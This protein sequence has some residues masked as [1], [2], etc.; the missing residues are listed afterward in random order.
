MR[1]IKLRHGTWNV[2]TDRPLG[3][4][5]GFGAVFEGVDSKGN[6]V[7]IKILH[8][9]DDIARELQ[10]AEYFFAKPANHVVPILDFGVDPVDSTTCIVMRR[11][12]TS[13]RADLQRVGTFSEP[14]CVNILIDLARGLIEAGSWVHRDLKPDNALLFDGRWHLADF[15]LARQSD[16][17]TVT[18]TVRHCMTYPYAAPEQFSGIR[19]THATDIYSL[20]C[21]GAE[22]LTG[23]LV[24][25]GPE[26]AMQHLHQTPVVEGASPR[27]QSLLL[28]MMAKPME[29]RPE[30]E[31]VLREIEEIR[32]PR[33]AGGAGTMRLQNAVVRYNDNVAREE[34][35]QF[36]IQTRQQNRQRLREAA[37]VELAAVRERLLDAIRTFVPAANMTI[38]KQPILLP[39]HANAPLRKH[40]GPERPR[41]ELPVVDELN[42]VHVHGA[43]GSGRLALTGVLMGVAESQFSAAEWDVIAGAAVATW[44]QNC[45]RSAS[46]WYASIAGHQARWYEVAYWHPSVSWYYPTALKPGNDAATAIK[47]EQG[48]HGWGLSYPVHELGAGSDTEFLDRWLGWFGDA[49]EGVLTESAVAPRP[50]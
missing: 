37:E 43:Y 18:H 31:T 6:P 47:A 15:G 25:S 40:N 12:Q 22:L 28:R 20:G 39:R 33:V 7:A 11:A 10:F 24:F 41:L 3:N 4:P 21:I 48:T 30:V 35:K 5:G 38:P 29:A 19:A 13:L 23:R 9:N 34:A 42:Q 36:E 1:T 46:L 2:D 26:F 8:R 50:V 44:Q 17:A 45:S 49:V 27:L 16:A 14:E 32:T